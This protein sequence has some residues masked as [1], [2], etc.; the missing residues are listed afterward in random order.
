[1]ARWGDFYGWIRLAY[2]GF[3]SSWGSDGSTLFGS[4][5]PLRRVGYM[6]VLWD[7]VLLSP[8]DRNPQRATITQRR[9]LRIPWWPYWSPRGYHG[10]VMIAGKKV[11]TT[12]ARR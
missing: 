5:N 4:V 6:G 8:D 9:H 2:R 11:Q 12:L 1:M 7:D 3:A 10:A